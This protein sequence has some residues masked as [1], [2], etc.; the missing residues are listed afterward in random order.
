MKTNQR[1]KDKM[2][3]LLMSILFC[4]P[5]SRS[6]GQQSNVTNVLKPWINT[7]DASLQVSNPVLSGASN[8]SITTPLNNIIDNDTNNRAVIRLVSSNKPQLCAFAD[9]TISSVAEIVINSTH[10]YDS[11]N[12][13]SIRIDRNYISGIT[14]NTTYTLLVSN[15]GGNDYTALN[16]FQN[17]TSGITTE[18]NILSGY[19]PKKYKFVKIVISQGQPTVCGTSSYNYTISHLSVHSKKDIV[20]STCNQRLLI[21]NNTPGFISNDSEIIDV[22]TNNYAL[23]YNSGVGFKYNG[24]LTPGMFAGF[25]VKYTGLLSGLLDLSLLTSLV[26]TT[27]LHGSLQETKTGDNLVLGL[28]LLSN[29]DPYDLGLILTKPADS[30]VVSH[31][32]LLDGYRV[33][34]PIIKCYSDPAMI[35]CNEYDRLVAPKYPVEISKNTTGVATVGIGSNGLQNIDNLTNNDPN[36]YAS[37]GTSVNLATTSSIILKKYQMPFEANTFA[38]IELEQIGV[39]NLEVLGDMHVE[40]Y[41]NDSLVKSSEGT[42]LITLGVL[43]GQ[44]RQVI[45]L[46]SDTT[47]NEIRLVI[48]STIGANLLSSL[49]LY[50]FVYKKFCASTIDLSCTSTNRNRLVQMTSP[51]Y[52]LYVD[53]ALTGVNALVSANLEKQPINFADNAIDADTSNYTSIDITALVGGSLTY[54]VA[55]AVS[56]YPANTY[57]AFDISTKKLIDVSALSY[58]KISLIKDGSLIGTPFS[59]SLLAGVSLLNANE[60]RYKLG[61][62]AD[63]EFDGIQL[64]IEGV[65]QVGVLGTLK[66]HGVWMEQLCATNV[67]CNSTI[68][69]VQ[70]E[71]PVIINNDRTGIRGLATVNLLAS[72]IEDIEALIDDDALNYTT[73]SGLVKL[74]DVTSISVLNPVQT[75]PAGS[76]AGFIVDLPASLIDLGLIRGIRIST[77]NDNALQESF[78][79]ANLLNLDLLTLNILGAQPGSRFVGINT[80][81]PYDEIVIEFLGILGVDLDFTGTKIYGAYVSTNGVQFLNGGLCSN[82]LPDVNVCIKNKVSNGDLSTNDFFSGNPIVTYGSEN[83]TTIYTHT[84]EPGKTATITLNQDGTYTVTATDTGAY[85][86]EI[87]VVINDGLPVYS[88][89]RITVIDDRLDENPVIANDDIAYIIGGATPS[90]TLLNVLINDAAGNSNR[91]LTISSPSSAAGGSVLVSSGMIEYTP[92]ANFYGIDTVYY[93]VIDATA[94]NGPIN[95]SAKVVVYVYDPATVSGVNLV[96]ATDDYVEVKSSTGVLSIPAAQ[97]L[98][99]ND[100]LLGTGTLTM[101]ASS[102]GTFYIDPSNPNVGTISIAANG[103]YTI[104]PGSGMLA[105]MSYPF[106]YSISNGGGVTASGTMYIMGIFDAPLPITLVKFTADKVDCKNVNITWGTASE[107]NVSHF[108]IEYSATASH[109]VTIATHEAKGEMFSNTLY[110]QAVSQSDL[111]GYYRLKT[112]DRDGTLSYSKIAQVQMINCDFAAYM[113]VPNPSNG[114][115]TLHGNDES[116]KVQ[117]MDIT[118]KVIYE[119]TYESLAQ[120]KIDIT[121]YPTGTYHLRMITENGKVVVFKLIK[122]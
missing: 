99:A 21:S 8:T 3:V 67:T 75:Y 51:T 78:T 101:D 38:G 77:Y 119:K 83:P 64:S 34:S 39:A 20:L 13:L 107:H 17:S 40:L 4:M 111:I 56:N 52:P 14:S 92:P 43:S 98:L 24:Y 49:R 76:S 55:D 96:V 94:P 87:P 10:E 118:G 25:K 79:T 23:A 37:F 47:Y 88:S 66:I 2:L 58:M 108:E 32:G 113:V 100:R 89:L 84:I 72:E 93:D 114:S 120:V 54:A 11:N 28:S 95:G 22:D 53:G 73:V 82:I 59:P 48:N 106:V 112:V 70:G 16:R 71:A 104:T 109:F 60:Q 50:N 1:R 62:V 6:I 80:T 12:Y 31:A 81:K 115:F 44:N 122:Y 45:G 110:T 61:I 42:G 19:A 63:Q 105:S 7:F 117:V 9:E 41:Y 46:M 116:G 103:S 36:S 68:N 18:T 15:T 97:G 85:N 35:P 69:L 33:Y 86:F 102:I 90:A 30:V 27:Y 74:G 91:P 121:A 29:S 5:F 57:I 65:A 26:L